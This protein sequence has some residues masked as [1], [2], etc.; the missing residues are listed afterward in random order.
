M[1]RAARSQSAPQ[2]H[3]SYWE[4]KSLKYDCLHPR[5]RAMAEQVV[6]LAPRSVLDV[7]CS[8]GEMG[9]AIQAGLPT[10]A[11]YGCDIS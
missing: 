6:R 2:N 9:R 3:R 11:Y 10:A 8:T 5:M 4:Q 7:G 1:A